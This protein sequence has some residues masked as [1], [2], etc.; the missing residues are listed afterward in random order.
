L[1]G[2]TL[3][4]RWDFLTKKDVR[5]V[6]G[7]RTIGR[8]HLVLDTWRPIQM[9][10]GEFVKHRLGR[11]HWSARLHHIADRLK[12]VWLISTQLRFIANPPQRLFG[13]LRLESVLTI[14]PATTSRTGQRMH[15]H[16]TL[17]RLVRLEQ[18]LV[19]VCNQIH[20]RCTLVLLPTP[21]RI[22]NVHYDIAMSSLVKST[23][24]PCTTRRRCQAVAQTFA[25]GEARLIAALAITCAQTS[26][27]HDV[28]DLFV[29]PPRI[30][31]RYSVNQNRKAHENDHHDQ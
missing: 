5:S 23:R 19:V 28:F 1:V 20:F 21:M 8:Q 3:R 30:T 15:R 26:T 27:V 10:G 12:L 25:T 17:D 31:R 29:A 11:R 7:L 4:R 2:G 13:W 22:P 9:L 14:S 6:V 16:L 18:F 24:V